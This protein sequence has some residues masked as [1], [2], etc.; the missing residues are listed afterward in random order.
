MPIAVVK[1]IRDIPLAELEIGM[2]QV[3]TNKN[4]TKDIEELAESI[5]QVGLLEPIVVCPADAPGKY[6]ILTGQRRFQA[7]RLLNHATISAAVLDRKLS[8]PEAKIVSVTENLVRLDLTRPEVKDAISYLYYHYD[9]DVKIVAEKVGLPQTRIREVIK[10]DRLVPELK[11]L[12]QDGTA[13]LDAAIRAQDAASVGRNEPDV[14]E[15]VQ[16]AKTMSSMTKNQK[17]KLQKEK[18]SNPD[19]SVEELIEKAETG[20]FGTQIIIDVSTTT[21]S[22]LQSFA[23]AEGLTQSDAAATFI[24][25]GLND[26][27]FL[28]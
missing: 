22:A 27:G 10:Y 16:L 15:A 6:Q 1:E 8:E 17:E 20:A 7:V 2:G 11:T 18:R 12:V 3:R 23:E 25:A 9:Q 21:H 26:A 19:T 13:T 28:S 14:D 4:A 24:E 5:Q